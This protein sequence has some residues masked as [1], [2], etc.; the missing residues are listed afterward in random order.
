MLVEQR[1]DFQSSEENVSIVMTLT[2]TNR[3]SITQN[4]GYQIE[5]SLPLQIAVVIIVAV[6]ISVVGIYVYHKSKIKSKKRRR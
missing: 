2:E 5:F 1:D 4:S 6:L 3:W